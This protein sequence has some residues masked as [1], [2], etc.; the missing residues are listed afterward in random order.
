[1]DRVQ[2]DFINHVAHVRMVRSDKMNAL[3]AGMFEALVDAGRAIAEAGDVRAVVLS[4]EGR[5]F[6]AGL[7]LSN[8]ADNSGQNRARID[9][10]SRDHDGI[11]MAQHAVMQWRQLPVPVIAA[12]HDV[13]FGGGFQLALGADMRFV[14]PKARMALM[15]VKWGLIPDM[16][17]MFL[18][19][20]L[21][22]RDQAAELLASGRIFTGEEAERL[23][24]ATRLCDDPVAEALQ[25][26]REIA[27]RSPD[28][29]RAGK[30]LLSYGDDTSWVR[31]LNA[32]AIEQ[33]ALFGKAN[34][35]EAVRA[36]MAKD[37]PSFGPASAAPLYD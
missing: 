14:A 35:V 7:D 15:E 19:R 12:V 33:Q 18:L 27:G 11:N 21:V 32:E 24:L 17:G 28:A 31:I 30:R 34:Q 4:G 23:G 6:C 1:M 9:I 2:T 36:G 3:D 22:R 29:I 37:A 20:G 8:L 13:A 16:G 25:F 5:G 10:S 26:A